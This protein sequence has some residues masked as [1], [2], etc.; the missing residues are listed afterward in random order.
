MP[1]LKKLLFDKYDGFADKRVKKLSK[2]SVFVVD[3]RSPNDESSSGKLY[4]SFCMIFA[5]VRSNNDVQVSLCGNVP[6]GEQVE[7]W[8]AEHGLSVT[9]GIQK[10][11]A[12]TVTPGEE[13]MLSTLAD[14]IES[15]VAP[16][17]RYPV[18]SYKYACPKTAGSLRRLKYVL[19][20]AWKNGPIKEGFGLLD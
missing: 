9:E 12:F 7:E 19:D 16:G 13:E 15:I 14:A 1:I 2:A 11:L 8:L 20:S 10:R 18:K 3:D 6:G 17:N 4:L 5:N